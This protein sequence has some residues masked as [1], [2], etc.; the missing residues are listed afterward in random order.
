MLARTKPEEVGLAGA[1]TDAVLN[2]FQLSILTEGSGTQVFATTFVQWAAREALRR[3]QPTT[4]LV[5]FAPRQREKPMNELLA[6][7]QRKPELDPQGSL[8]DADM[9]A[10]YT[11]LNQQR[12]SDAER[13]T[14][15]AWFEGHKDAIYAVAIS[16]NKQILAT[17]SY[18][19]KIILWDIATGKLIKELEGHNSARIR[20]GNAGGV[21]VLFNGKTIGSLGPRGQVRT[22][23]FTKDN[24]EIVEPSAHIALTSFSP[25]GE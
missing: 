12:L 20:T 21:N 19:Q 11:W 17:G 16:P 5:R 13:A 2:R 7:A 14:F 15:I 3:A 4:M 8:V 25:S 23:V 1:G 24:Y 22:V 6:E 9:G 18:D 10:Y